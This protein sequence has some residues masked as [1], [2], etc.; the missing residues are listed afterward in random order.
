MIILSI[1]DKVED[2]LFDVKTHQRFADVDLVLGCGDLPYYYLEFL[3]DSLN[4]PVMFVRGNHAAAVE[5]SENGDRTKPN[6]AINLHHRVIRHQ[7]LIIAGF[8][9]SVRYRS[10]FYQYTQAQM[11]WMVLAMMPVLLWNRLVHHRWLDILISHSP[12]WGINDQSDRAHQG[13]KALRWL[14][15][16]CKP[17]YHFHGHVHVN[18]ST[19]I[20]ETL[21]AQT[22]VVNTYGYRKTTIDVKVIISRGK[23]ESNNGK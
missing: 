9:G 21:H 18:S 6:G 22:A 16:V 5:Y 11:W 17:A 4:I 10:G 15:E 23:K 19:K 13:F 3:V 20:V 7:G 8:E 2:I 1:S 14:L 12:P